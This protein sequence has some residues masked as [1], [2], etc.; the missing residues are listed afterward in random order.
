MDKPYSE[1]PVYKKALD[2][3]RQINLLCKEVKGQDFCF[4][5]DQLR[6][7]VSSIVLN[8]AEGSG[9]WN[10]KDKVNFYRIARASAFECVGGIDLV[11]AYQ[12]VKA[13]NLNDLKHDFVKIAGEIQALIFGVERRKE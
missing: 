5:R 8:L 10:K 12:L 7:A 2:A 6:R 11:M 3:A 13:Q 1:F 9:K 4:L